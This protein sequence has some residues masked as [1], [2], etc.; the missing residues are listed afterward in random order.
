MKKK[1]LIFIP[2][3]NEE[4]NIKKII[5]SIFKNFNNRINILFIDD[6][7]QDKTQQQIRILKKKYKNIFLHTRPKKLG[8]GSAHKKAFLI[9]KKKKYKYLVTMDC[10]GTHNPYYINKLLESQKKKNSEI[11]TTNRFLVKGSLNSWSTWRKILT[12]IRHLLIKVV[13]KINYDSSGAFR[14]YNLNLIK[15]KD[16]LS[17]KHNGY[18]FFWESIFILFKKKYLIHEIPIELPFRSI[19]SSK[20]KISDIINAFI[21][22]III[23]MKKS[24]Y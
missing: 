16:F 5:F 9:A 21:Y 11:V 8:I 2:V 23:S 24:K 13:L 1:I 7:S 14:L 4:K 18:S 3:Y 22:V 15:T 12:W 10:D 17:A 19:G 6:N 20:M